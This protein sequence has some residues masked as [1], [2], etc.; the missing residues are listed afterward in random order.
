MISSSPEETASSTTYWMIGLSTSGSISFGCAL[1]AGRKR[2]PRPAAGNTALRTRGRTNSDRSTGYTRAPFTPMLDPRFVA[3]NKERVLEAL[4]QRGQSLEQ[5]GGAE[6]WPVDGERRK[7]LQQVEELRHRQRKAGEESA[8]LG[9]EKQDTSALRAEMK[10]VADEIKSLEERL[11][12][13][14]EKLKAI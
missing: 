12:A 4:A 9:R 2:V 7:A 14:D 5:G 13:L 1:V 8:R 10:G 11:A 3:E 6:R